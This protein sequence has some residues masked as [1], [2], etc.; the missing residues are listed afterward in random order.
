MKPNPNLDELLSSFIDGELSPRQRT[1]VQRMAAHDPAVARRL[2]QLQNCRTLVCSLPPAEAPGEL[3]EQ[4]RQSLERKT[5]LQEQPVSARRS[6]GVVHLLFRRF[7]AAA[8][9]IAL[10]GVLGAVV[11]QIVAPVPGTQPLSPMAVSPSPLR[12]VPDLGGAAPAVTVVDRGLSGRLELATAAFVQADAFVK[13][14]IEACG[15]VEIEH[16]EMADDRRVYRV[17][18]TREGLHRLVASLGGVWQE[19]DSATLHVSEP[20]GSAPVTIEGVTPDQMIE[21]VARRSTEAS[22]ET[23]QVYA[24]MNQM[25]RNMPGREI[26]PLMHEDAGSLFAADAVPMPKLAGPADTNQT[27]HTPPTQGTAQASLTIVLLRSS[28]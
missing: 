12:P 19:F 22:V 2:R 21:V 23:A 8:A 6:A 26:A 14:A 20:E 1:E 3:L 17:T 24:V 9:M 4:I 13:R 16:P 25:T 28:K 18:G 7:V 11:Y 27:T 10:L 15:S 5:L